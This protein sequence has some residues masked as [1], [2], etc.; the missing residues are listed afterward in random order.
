MVRATFKAGA[1]F[2]WLRLQQI[3][4]C[5]GRHFHMQIDAIKQGATELA[6]VARH[7]IG[8]TTAG[9]L[10]RAQI[11]TRAGIHGAYQLKAC[12]KF[13]AARCPCDGDRAGLQWFAQSLQRG[14]RKFRH[15][16][17][18]EHPMMRQ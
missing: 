12:R 3:G 15:F 17:K 13:R 14:T 18:V 8:R 5:D 11:A 2:T 4:R 9:F 16:I 10:L 6:L 7:L 1:G